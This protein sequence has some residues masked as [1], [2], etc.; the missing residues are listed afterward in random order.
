MT[1]QTKLDL[2]Q[3]SDYIIENTLREDSLLSALREETAKLP[4]ASM[5]IAP[6]QGQFMSLLIKLMGATRAIEIGTY[7]GYSAIA[8]GRAL[9]ENG[10]LICCDINETWTSIAQRYW[11]EAGLSQ[12]IEL[13]L[14]DASET[15]DRLIAE[16]QDPF[17][18]VFIDA[19]KARYTHYY[20]QAKTLLRPGGLIAIDNVLW[21]GKVIDPTIT[22]EETEAIRQFNQHVHQ[23]NSVDLSMVPIADGITLARKR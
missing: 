2:S 15:L 3:L 6:E 1:N 18:F 5:Q 14:G 10:Q 22:D 16:H 20:E 23:D 7:T 13:R 9:P 4:N 19:D 21:S 11:K 17:D 8:V 12:I